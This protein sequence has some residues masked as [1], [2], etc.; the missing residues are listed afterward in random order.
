MKSRG[1][2]YIA[3]TKKAYLEAALISALALRQH[4]PEIP[5]TL[6][7]DQPLLK[8]LPLDEYKISSRLL[9]SN[10]HNFSSRDIKTRLNAF[11]PYQETLFLDAD[12]IPLGPISGLWDYIA[13]GDMAMVLD[14]L[15]RVSL[16]DHV[17]QAEKSYTL[18]QLPGNTSQYN[19]GLMLWRNTPAIQSL[20]SQWHQEWRLFE[21][22]DQLA[23]VRAIHKTQVSI[24][25]L[26]KTYNISPIDAVDLI[27]E[28]QKAHLLHCWGGMTASGKF[29]E[30]AYEYYPSIVETVVKLVGNKC[31]II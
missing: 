6:I 5:I 27:L 9:E 13:K 24:N 29:R 10:S 14:R 22:Q 19:S 3:T 2:I 15:P 1:V 4:E 16:C 11:S 17:S 20:F 26:P 25:N 28:N 31:S 18:E 7:C 21:K 30:L 8:L 23:L 12:I